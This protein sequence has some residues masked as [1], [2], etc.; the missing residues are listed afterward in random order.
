MPPRSPRSVFLCQTC[1]GQT[2]RW[3]GRCPH[4]EAWNSLVE[5]V[6]SGPPARASRGGN[7][8]RSRPVSLTRLGATTTAERVT[9]GIGEFDRVL[10]GGIVPGS[11]ALV[12]GDPGIGKSTLLLIAAARIAGDGSVLYVSGE[13]SPEQIAM[14]ARRLGLDADGLLILAETS[15]ESIIEQAGGTA[16][17]LLVVD[18]IQTMTLGDVDSPAGS[19]TQVRECAMALLRFAKDSGIPVMLVGHVTKDGAIAGP[20]IL[21]HI[22]DVVLHLEGERF[23]AYRVLRGI[24]NRY[25][26]TDE[27]G[28]FE[29]RDD[30]LVEVA[31]PSSAFISERAG[32]ADGSAIAVTLEGTRPILVEVQALTAPSNL[33]MP[34]RTANGIDANRLQLLVAVLQRRVGIPLGNQDVYVNVAGG[35]R[36]VEPALDMAVALAIA[37][38]YRGLPI[39]ADIAV[40][41]EIGL[42]GEA[43]RVSQIDRRLAEARRLGFARCVVPR[44]GAVRGRADGLLSAA[45][46]REAIQVTWPRGGHGVTDEPIE[47]ADA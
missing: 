19:V 6:E 37:S 15:V 3:L 1:G 42:N 45:T 36:V 43:R 10:G 28:V 30:G 7:T 11:I 39:P 16:P 8:S 26:S 33:G 35:I 23:N 2:P 24:K 12:G 38:S 17:R 5:T 22:V 40:I 47:A 14:R 27:I 32:D 29:M 25:G 34:R 13:E 44:S 31:N 4:C 21:E 46:V 41:G 20:R 9:T 18:S